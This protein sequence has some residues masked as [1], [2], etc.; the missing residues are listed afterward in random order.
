LGEDASESRISAI[1][2]GIEHTRDNKSPNAALSQ[3]H[4]PVLKSLS[5]GNISFE[6]FLLIVKKKWKNQNSTDLD[7]ERITSYEHLVAPKE[8]EEKFTTSELLQLRKLFAHYD[9][10]CGMSIAHLEAFRQYYKNWLRRWDN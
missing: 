2:R 7:D 3:D 4:T 6:E 8:V 5:D 1:F 9:M 10:G